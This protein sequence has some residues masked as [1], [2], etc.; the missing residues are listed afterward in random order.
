YSINVFLTF[1]LTQLGMV[2]HWW[3][4][5]REQQHWHRRLAIAA[6]GTALT[7]L[8]LVITA[9]IKFLD[10]GWVT[11]LVT[12]VLIGFCFV[13]RSHYRRVRAMLS[14]LD[15]TLTQLPLP[16]PKQLP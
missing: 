13:V 4:T 10:G 12:G 9:F 8:I 5:R 1:T 2:R 3:N 15:E 11:L 6:T 16:E 7:S 14:T